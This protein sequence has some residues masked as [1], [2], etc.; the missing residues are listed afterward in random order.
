MTGT[1][2]NV[3]TVLVGSTIGLLIR[4]RLPER[5][6]KVIFQVFG[7]FTIFLGVKMAMETRELMVMIFSLLTGT[8]LGEW[9]N[10][11]KGMDRLAGFLKRKVKSNHERFSE[12]LMTSF[13]VFCMGSMT[14]LGAIEEGLGEK[15]NLLL[16]KALMDG[17][18]SMAFASVMGIGV[19]FSVI[20]LFLYQGGLTLFA[21]SVGSLLS[22]PILAEVTAVGGILLIGLGFNLL[23]V[24]KIRVMNMLPSLVLAVV[25]AKWLPPLLERLI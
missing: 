24:K 7:L 22:D 18:S 3:I 11:E 21:G 9:M 4:S 5:F 14:V 13:L 6:S 12:G 15:P 17:F 16:T 8:L 19:L 23:D 20:P 2:I 1:I 10:L 25:L